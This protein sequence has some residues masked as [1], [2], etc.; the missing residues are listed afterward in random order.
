MFLGKI[1]TSCHSVR[2]YLHICRKPG[3]LLKEYT[4]AGRIYNLHLLYQAFRLFY[5]KKSHHLGKF[6]NEV[7]SG[8]WGEIQ[9]LPTF[10][11]HSHLWPLQ[12]KARQ[13]C[14]ESTISI[15]YKKILMILLACLIFGFCIG[16]YF[17]HSK[18]HKQKMNITK[19][20]HTFIQN[21]Q[22]PSNSN[23]LTLF[24]KVFKISY[25]TYWV[26]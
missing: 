21:S 6:T 15:V 22:Q 18:T 24:P 2:W 13:L 1:E 23:F 19:E 17:V 14:E 25:R 4:N 26:Y 10:L 8:V 11:I 20:L 7:I 9:N 5:L 3:L 12:N 16:I